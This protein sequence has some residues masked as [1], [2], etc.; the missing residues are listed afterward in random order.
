MVTGECWVLNLT[1]MIFNFPNNISWKIWHNRKICPWAWLSL[2]HIIAVCCKICVMSTSLNSFVSQNCIGL[3]FKCNFVYKWNVLPKVFAILW[4]CITWG[5][6]FSQFLN[7]NYF[8]DMDGQSIMMWLNTFSACLKFL[9]KEVFKNENIPV[10]LHRQDNLLVLHLALSLACLHPVL[11]LMHSN[12][13]QTPGTQFPFLCC[14]SELLQGFADVI[15]K[16]MCSSY[17][18]RHWSHSKAICCW[19][20]M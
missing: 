6:F 11:K 3:P 16:G 9:N 18:L 10:Q 7:K 5:G 19:S 1:M 13:C 15:K 20:Q 2:G 14:H 8:F 4:K 12:L 17:E